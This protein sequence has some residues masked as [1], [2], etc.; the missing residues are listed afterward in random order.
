[1]LVS[2]AEA[3]LSYQERLDVLH[4]NFISIGNF[5]APP[6]VHSLWSF[7][8]DQTEVQ[9]TG[10][11]KILDVTA[12]RLEQD[13]QPPLLFGQKV[14]LE[15]FERTFPLV[16]TEG[17]VQ[18]RLGTLVLI[19][20][21]RQVHSSMIRMLAANFV[22]NTLVIVIIILLV[23]YAYHSQVRRR[24]AQV[25]SELSNTEPK[26]LRKLAG[27]E[28]GSEPLRDEIDALVAAIVKLKSMGGRALNAIDA[29]NLELEVLL[30]E[31]ADSQTLLQSVIDTSPVR[32]FWK[33]R[34]LK[35]LGCNPAFAQ[36][37]GKKSP[38][39]LIGRDD[40]SMGWAAQAELYRADDRQVMESG[41]PR[42]GFEE[43][44]STP[45]GRMTWIRTSKVP[46][47]NTA[48]EVV[49][50][51]GMYEDITERKASEQKLLESESRFRELVESIPGFAYRC[52]F[53]S[54]WT[55]A[56]FSPGFTELTGHSIEDF[57]DN[58]VRSYA[59]IIHPD[60]L[61]FVDRVVRTGTEN[62]QPFE[63]EYRIFDSQGRIIW[64]GERGCGHF[65]QDGQTNYLIG[66]I[67]D[68]TKRKQ[69]ELELEQHRHRL[70]E[71]VVEQTQDL[72]TAK[73]MAET[74]NIAKSAFLANMSHEIRTP[75]NAIT[76]MTYILRRHGVSVHQADK[77]EKIETASKHLLEIINS[78]LDLSKIE[79]GK[80]SLSE[81][82]IRPVDLIESVSNMIKPQARAKGLT[83]TV[84]LPSLPDNLI[85]DH[86][87]L[88]QALLNYL[89]NAVKFTDAG[90]IALRAKLVDDS[91][92]ATVLRFEVSDTGPGIP[93]E[94]LSKLFSAFEQAD[95]TVTRKY[96]GTGLGLAI[97]R[98]IARLM[99][100]EAGVET[101]LG[102]GSTFWLTV[103]LRKSEPSSAMSS[104]QSAIDV[105]KALKRDFSGSKVLLAEDEPINREIAQYLLESVGLMTTLAEDGAQAFEL[106]RKYDY[107]LILMDMRMPNMDGLEATRRIRQLPGG[108]HTP[109]LAMTANA[110]A[111]DKARCFEAGMNDF[112]GKPASPENLF[113]VILY[114][115]R[116]SLSPPSGAPAGLPGD[117]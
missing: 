84:D 72:R 57:V 54:N 67:F 63:I 105:E 58:R 13:G 95:N 42:L 23:L 62:R 83:Y 96:G 111:E 50:V 19:K 68:I 30:D 41:L 88:R 31:L 110:F 85:G 93:P 16:H 60:D 22:G 116:I 106:A 114:W 99:D 117:L 14:V 47:R 55:M 20:D 70:Q 44:Q 32:V 39:E 66:V 77:L 107:D 69:N 38:S 56:Y 113:S 12:V 74:A 87:R 4:Q 108:K 49:G 53:D 27:A 61:D 28:P 8:N 90:S 89:T 29:R 71:L 45:D 91:A 35:Y 17:D 101:R 37:A 102:A 34:E 6:L 36:D 82:V 2:A 81:E 92:D 75:L 98:K 25:V 9:L 21:M 7:D 3:L 26:D 48:N 65:D 46:L 94:F 10:F 52:K 78:V 97:T 1:M 80:F 115:L 76:G 59:S 24:L 109:I 103:R 15:K 79:A 5:V 43:P 51:L 112:I 33:N 40:F 104:V 11:V 86:T 100:G 18:H 73:E 64:V